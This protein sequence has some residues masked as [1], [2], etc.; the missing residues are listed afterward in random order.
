MW[1]GWILLGCTPSFEDCNDCCAYGECDASIV[2]T[3]NSIIDFAY[4]PDGNDPL[5]RYTI[6]QGFYVMTTEMSQ[7]MFQALMGYS[8]HDGF[9]AAY[10]KGSRHPAYYVNWHMAANSA[11]NLTLQHNETYGSSF[12]PCY[13]CSAVDTLEVECTH[14]GSPYACSG[15]RLPTDIEWEYFAR[16]GTTSDFWTGKGSENGGVASSDTCNETVMIL[17]N[18]DSPFL[19]ESAWFCHTNS[20]QPIAS[21]LPNGFGLYDIHG[22]LWEWTNDDFGCTFPESIYEHHCANLS[23]TRVGRGGSFTIFPSYAVVGGR[24]EADMTRRDHS[25]GFRLVRLAN[26]TVE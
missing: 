11:N 2:L 4:I 13:T 1:F 3:E 7:G 6:R 9:S 26:R 17:D 16:S 12:E 23:K 19:A 18:V 8:A 15:Y 20:A 21:L 22:N 24:F 10:G 25:I 14:S 5:N